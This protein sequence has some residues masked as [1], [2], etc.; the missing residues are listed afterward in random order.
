MRCGAAAA[1]ASLKTSTARRPR[2]GLSGGGLW[3]DDGP[4]A[5]ENQEREDGRGAELNG[6]GNNMIQILYNDYYHYYYKS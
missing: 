5:A 6:A 4:R 3:P 1:R 2:A